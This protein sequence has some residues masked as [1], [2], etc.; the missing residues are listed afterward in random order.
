[1]ATGA[2]F[3]PSTLSDVVCCAAPVESDKVRVAKR[4]VGWV[5]EAVMVTEQVPFGARLEQFDTA[6]K[7]EGLVPLSAGAFKVSAVVPVFTMLT[8]SEP[9][10]VWPMAT[11]PK[12]MEAGD[13][14]KCNPADNPT[15]MTPPAGLPLIFRVAAR[16]PCA[17]GV[18]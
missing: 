3:T 6:L 17:E 13:M 7:S 4:F 2:G 5:G 1:M 16:I 10:D 11:V 9:V 12:S 14:E 18:K 8:P 15:P